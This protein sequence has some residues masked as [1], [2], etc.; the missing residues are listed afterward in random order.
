MCN[1]DTPCPDSDYECFAERWT[2]VENGVD[3][4]WS[5]GHGCHSYQDL[6]CP[7]DDFAQTMDDESNENGSEYYEASCDLDYAETFSMSVRSA[8]LAAV[9]TLLA[10]S[11]TMF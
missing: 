4:E 3:I 6:K 9:T 5:R 2:Y 1:A 7:L 11:A 8:S 10:I